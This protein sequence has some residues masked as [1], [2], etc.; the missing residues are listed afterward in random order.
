M[1]SAAPRRSQMLPGS[2][3]VR[4]RTPPRT[5][6]GPSCSHRPPDALGCSQ[7]LP[8]STTTPTS[9]FTATTTTTTFNTTTTAAA[10]ATVATAAAATAIASATATAV[11]TAT[12]IANA[13]ATATAAYFW[14][15]FSILIILA[16]RA[17][18][19]HL[20]SGKHLANHRLSKAHV[21]LVLIPAYDS[22]HSPGY[23]SV[24]IS[25][26]TRLVRALQTIRA[27]IRPRHSSDTQ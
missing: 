25:T 13:T 26:Q 18:V 23:H 12:A 3:R 9:P 4:Y 1:L 10:A 16:H 22:Y 20:D 7:M 5:T 15:I 19:S 17:R 11:P 24:A 21:H 8:V 27:H 6:F 14:Q 2:I